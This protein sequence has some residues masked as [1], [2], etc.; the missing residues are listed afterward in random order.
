M[1]NKNINDLIIRAET[2]EAVAQTYLGICYMLGDGVECDQEKA[3]S[4]YLKAAE[5]N[6]P[7]ALTNAGECYMHGIGT[8]KNI[9]KAIQLLSKACE[10]NIPEALNSL[11]II[12]ITGERTTADPEKAVALF[13][14]AAEQSLPESFNNLWCCYLEGIGTEK[15]LAKALDYFCK[16]RNSGAVNDNQYSYI[17][18]KINVDELTALSI[19][20]NAQA[21]CFLACMYL[22]GINIEKD[23][24]M[25]WELIFKAS[26]QG[27]PLALFLYGRLCFDN[28]DYIMAEMILNKAVEAGSPNA[29]S[30]LEDTREKIAETGTYFLVKI[31]DKQ[32]VDKFL[33]GDIFMRYLGYFGLFN[34]LM[35]K[36]SS[37]DNNFRGDAT[38][39]LGNST[40][41]PQS[42]PC[43]DGA[44]ESR[45]EQNKI[46]CLYALDVSAKKNWIAPID[47]RIQDFGDTAVVIL[48]SNEFLRRLHKAFT[49]RFGYAFRTSYKR[50]HYDL[51][52]SKARSYSEFNKNIS[53]AWQRE[54]RISLDLSEGRVSKRT[55]DLMTDFVRFQYPWKIDNNEESDFNADSLTVNIGDI[56]DICLEIPTREFVK[57]I[58]KLIDDK[59]IP[60]AIVTILDTPHEPYIGVFRP[61]MKYPRFNVD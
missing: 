36:G 20:G 54:F 57:N 48:D 9:D 2:G 15:N 51:D 10:Y 35:S 52:F 45:L 11:G 38:E 55:W 19:D 37:V 27:E 59:Y 26:R 34:Q 30:L 56:R 17:C 46:F 25:A 12:L 6:E 33:D 28:S 58:D 21:Q 31:L 41:K 16:A 3:L 60:P 14:R 50:V 43:I 47:P 8:K 5:Q 18:N 23:L 29:Q 40:G 1:F 39:G 53:Y 32:W 24:D 42:D 49:D 7:S 61:V 13:T 44:Y 4:W 22:S